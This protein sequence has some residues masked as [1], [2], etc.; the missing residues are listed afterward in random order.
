[1]CRDIWFHNGVWIIIKSTSYKLYEM[2]LPYFGYDTFKAL[3][4]RYDKSQYAHIKIDYLVYKSPN[5]VLYDAQSV[6][7]LS[8]QV[9]TVYLKLI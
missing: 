5:Q 3:G 1:M 9:I 4:V 7:K 8:G 2:Y 6:S